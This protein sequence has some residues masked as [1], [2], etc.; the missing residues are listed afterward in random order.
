MTVDSGD[1]EGVFQIHLNGAIP[2]V[3][4]IFYFTGLQVEQSDLLTSGDANALFSPGNQDFW[5]S[6]WAKLT[7][8]GAGGSETVVSRSISSGWEWHIERPI[9][10]LWTV[11][12]SANGTTIVDAGT[13]PIVQ[14]VWAHL[15]LQFESAG[16]LLDIRVNNGE[17]D[18][19]PLAGM[20]QG[21]TASVKIGDDGDS[22]HWFQGGIDHVMMGT[23][24]AGMTDSFSSIAAA[25]YNNGTGMNYGGLTPAQRS[26]FG[27]V[28]GWDMEDN[29]TSKANSIEL[30]N[31]GDLT[32]EGTE[33][34]VGYVTDTNIV[35]IGGSN[36]LFRVNPDI[37]DIDSRISGDTVANLFYVDASEDKIGIGTANPTQI[38]DVAGNA[39]ISGNVGIGSTTSPSFK[40]VV[41][42]SDPTELD[43]LDL[44]N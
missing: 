21:T 22:S 11:M 8:T 29:F 39:T 38:L 18:S 19:E 17:L 37:K 2:T 27:L 26:S 10:Q 7:G 28:D 43:A 20:F 40:L 31:H 14:D 9:A 12:G 25:L 16:G 15:F 6:A 36:L 24:A 3:G 4:A 30:N 34:G 1:L 23:A 42:G 33:Q 32:A 35:K 13:V 44:K 5:V 41:A